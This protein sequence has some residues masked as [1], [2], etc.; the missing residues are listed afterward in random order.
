MRSSG[1]SSARPGVG[2]ILSSQSA[3]GSAAVRQSS[4]ISAA[5]SAGM[6]SASPMRGRWERGVK[7]KVGTWCEVEGV[8]EEWKVQTRFSVEG[9]IE[10]LLRLKCM[11]VEAGFT[12][13]N[14][15]DL[16]D[17]D[18]ELRLEHWPSWHHLVWLIFHI[19]HFQA[20][21]FHHPQPLWAT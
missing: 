16:N 4:D 3:L 12:P 15:D 7:W 11:M 14:D 1:I 2:S 19:P 20:G 18:W 10:V 5:R 21:C 17:D 8:K 9:V 13:L 6:V